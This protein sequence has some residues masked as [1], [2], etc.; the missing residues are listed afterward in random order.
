[1]VR[2]VFEREEGAAARHV[3]FAAA[4][5]RRNSKRSTHH[6]VGALLAC[7]G[8]GRGGAGQNM[9]SCSSAGGGAVGRVISM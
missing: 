6:V 9:G 3:P 4:A 1:M 5:S 2:C 7:T 8:T